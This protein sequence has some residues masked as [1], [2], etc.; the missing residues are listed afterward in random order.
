MSKQPSGIDR[1]D[2]DAYI[3]GSLDEPGRKRMAACLS[4]DPELEAQLLLD[5]SVRCQLRDLFAP[6]LAE[7]IPKPMLDVLMRARLKGSH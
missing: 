4:D 5:H 6:V 3:A 2:L 7:P 1:R